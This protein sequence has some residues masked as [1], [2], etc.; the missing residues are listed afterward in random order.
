MAA[1]KIVSLHIELGRWLLRLTLIGAASFALGALMAAAAWANSEG[2]KRLG[3]METGSLML[4]STTPGLYVEAPR[5]ATDVKMTIS[6][7]IARTKITQRFTNA[8]EAWAEGI[9]VFPLPDGA[10]V[11]TLKMQIGERFIEGVIEERKKAK[12]IYEAAKREGKKASLLEQQRPNMFTNAVANIG[13]GETIVVQIEYQETVHMD[14]GTFSLRVPLVVAPRFNPLPEVRHQVNLDTSSG[15]GSVDPVPDREKI[16]PPVLHPE[17]GLV[18]PVTITVDLDAGFPLGSV[19]SSFHSIKQQSPSDSARLITLADEA[20]FADRDFELTW[21]PAP[22]AAPSAAMFKEMIDD[23]L[24][25]LLM[26]TPQ[27]G[28]AQKQQAPRDITF[29]IDTSGSMQGTSIGQAKQSLAMAIGRLDTQAHFNIIQFNS[30]MDM[31]FHAPVPATP[32]NVGLA[33]DYVR[34]LEAN[35]GTQMLPALSSALRHQ[36]SKGRLHQVVFLTDGAIGNERQLFDTIARD[37]GKARL[38]AVGIGSAPNSF[39]MTRAAELGQGSFT[40]IGDTAQVAERMGALLTKLETPAMTDIQTAWPTGT[41]AEAWPMPIPDLY[42]GET[43][44]IAA[45]ANRDSGTVTLSGQDG[46]SAWAADLSLDQAALRLGIGK[47][48]ARKKIASLE[49]LRSYPNAKPEEIDAGI[50]DVALT[51]GL[52]SRLTSLV[53]VDTTPSRPS[54][55]QLVSAEVPLNLPAGWDFEAVFGGSADAVPAMAP[56]PPAPLMRKVM[57]SQSVQLAAAPS[58]TG[59]GLALPATAILWE[60]RVLLGILLLSLSVAGLMMLRRGRA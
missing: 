7:P 12:A 58:Q 16:T 47:V 13:P 51:H 31:L 55:E 46:T 39:F 35:G 8:S 50:L 32:T 52:V 56:A 27:A 37:R 10:A 28:E 54:D 26:I 43:I 20:A 15:W 22:G 23:E 1:P 18:N 40:H 45:K 2:L 4:K 14:A 34:A 19:A 48:W 5:V 44:V 60:L 24:Y 41:K 42:F 3:E 59:A 6:G 30:Q 53:A 9:Y 25:Y 17:A 11:D 57:N 21:T 33:L 49:L 29:V 36:A 38:F